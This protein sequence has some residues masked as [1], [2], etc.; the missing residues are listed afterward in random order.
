V[1]QLPHSQT[2]RQPARATVFLVDPEPLYRWF[3]TESLSGCQ[4]NLLASASLEDAVGYLRGSG[5]VDLLIVDGELLDGHGQAQRL[6][7]DHPG[8]SL[9]VLDSAGD[10]SPHGLRDATVVAKPVDSA[11]L[12]ALV[13][14][15]LRRDVSAA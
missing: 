6:L 8:V 4:V 12:I 9:L 2:R 13:S 10:L 15:Q 7:A 14:R 3:A 11:A 5:H 1:F